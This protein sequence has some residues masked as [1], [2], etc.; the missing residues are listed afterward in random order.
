[1]FLRWLF[2]ALHLLA[3]GIGLGAIWGRHR[4]LRAELDKGGLRRVFYADNLWGAA[5]GLWLATGLVR[6]F[7]GLEKG[8]AYYL[9]ATMFRLKMGLFLLILALEIAPM[10]ALIRWRRQLARGESVDTSTARTY[11]KT[12]AVQAV[13]VAVMVGVA[14]A[15]ARGLQP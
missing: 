2:A 1:M 6:A 11:A 4:A 12:S 5:A 3:L 10:V 15:L 8:T 7:G 9:G 13:I 14:A